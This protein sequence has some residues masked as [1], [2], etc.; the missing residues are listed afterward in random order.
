MLRS[1]AA[2]T[3]ERTDPMTY[4]QPEKLKPLQGGRARSSPPCGCYL[5]REKPKGVRLFWA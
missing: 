4:L 3:Q 1:A 2:L 5:H